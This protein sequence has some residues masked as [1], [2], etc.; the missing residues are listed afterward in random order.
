MTC[1][2]A[3]AT[4]GRVLLGADSLIA[5]GGE[6]WPAGQPKIWLAGAG[7]YGVGFCGELA[8]GDLL[9]YHVRWPTKTTELPRRLTDCVTRAVART[10]LDLKK[11]EG[12]AV[13]CHA[14]RIYTI[15]TFLTVLPDARG[16]TAIGEA[17]LAHGVL[18]ATEGLK[19]T[20]KKR[21]TLALKAAAEHSRN[22]RK[23]WVWLKV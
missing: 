7:K 15:D 19:W 20:P 23:P 10:K 6:V 9:R 22:V 11:V 21:A 12:S 18:Y 17:D 2:V 16:Y 14:G 1:V 4:N 13:I 3:V 5:A 8:W